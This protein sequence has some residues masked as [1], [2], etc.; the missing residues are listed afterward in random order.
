MDLDLAEMSERSAVE[1]PLAVIVI[2]GYVG[3]LIWIGER[4]RR[5][6]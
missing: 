6:K 5:K 2:F 3:G 1:R 4:R